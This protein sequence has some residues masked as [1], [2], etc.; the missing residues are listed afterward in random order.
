MKTT[1]TTKRPIISE[2]VKLAKSYV[3][4]GKLSKNDFNALVKADPTEQKKFVGWMAKIWIREKPNI[5]VL[6]NTIEEYNTFLNK[7]RAKTKDIGKFKTFGEL[8]NE[9]EE[10]NKTGDNFSSRELETEYDVVLNTPEVLIASPHTHE[11]SR[12]LGLSMFQFRECSNGEKDSSWC[13]T[14]KAPDH[15]ND[16]YFSQNHTFYYVRVKSQDVMNKLAKV[17]PDNYKPLIVVAL[18][19]K[20]NGSVTAFNGLDEEMSSDDIK[21]YRSILKI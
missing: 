3:E 17:F 20:D 12:K 4:E 10:I 5:N 21:K 18:V 6:R 7:G 15:F 19:A 14:F 2:N 9:V 11:A 16:Y 1:T 13:T 8:H